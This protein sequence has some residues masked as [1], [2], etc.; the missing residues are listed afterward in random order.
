MKGSEFKD[1]ALQHCIVEVFSSEDDEM[2]Q[3]IKGN[4]HE[5]R[6]HLQYVDHP[7][8]GSFSLTAFLLRCDHDSVQ[9]SRKTIKG[10]PSAA[11]VK[12]EMRVVEKLA[13]ANEQSKRRCRRL[14]WRVRAEIRKAVKSMTNERRL[15]FRYDASSYALNFDDGD[16]SSSRCLDDALIF[17]LCLILFIYKAKMQNLMEISEGGGEICCG[18]HRPS[19]NGKENDDGDEIV[20][21][22]NSSSMNFSELV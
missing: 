13:W 12:K 6:L 18:S 9:H 19:A 4:R 15:M 14:Y 11:C 22:S 7:Q 3:E 20:G 16:A 1:H 17:A 21:H 2:L 10:E 8:M 5:K